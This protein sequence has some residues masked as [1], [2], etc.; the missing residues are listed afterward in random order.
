M[1]ALLIVDMQVGLRAGLPKHD[2][3]GVIDRINRLA[4][5][6]RRFGV[7]SFSFATAALPETTSSRRHRVGRSCRNFG[8]R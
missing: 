1:D 7:G 4:A 8:K 3:K 2:L 6:V 5:K